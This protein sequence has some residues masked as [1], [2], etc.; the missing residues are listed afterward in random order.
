M[1]N[2]WATRPRLV[3]WASMLRGAE[4][5]VL[6]C[7]GEHSSLGEKKVSGGRGT[8]FRWVMEATGEIS[9]CGVFCN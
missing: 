4:V 2:V 9:R 5:P 3:L 1:G 7:P 6:V 8:G